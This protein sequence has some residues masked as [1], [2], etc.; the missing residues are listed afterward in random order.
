[1]LRTI[2]RSSAFARASTLSL[3]LQLLVPCQAAWAQAPDQVGAWGPVLDWGVQ[4]K[5][6]V[7]LPTSKVLVW[8]T[9]ENARVWN[10]AT[11][12]FVPVPATFGDLHCAAQA[13]LADGRAIVIGGVLVDPHIGTKVTAIFDPFS[14]TWTDGRPMNYARWYGTATTLPDGRLLATSGDDEHGNR[15]T[16]PEIYDPIADTWTVLTGANRNQN[17]Y[18]FMYVL[19]NG[20]IYEAGTR[21]DT[22][23]L[24]VA[25]TGSWT[26][27]PDNSFGS[28]GYAECDA[29]YAPGKVV[30]AGGGDP[31][32]ADAAVIDMTAGSPQWRKIASM[33]FPRRRH[34]MVI[35]LDGSV[36]AVGGT[37]TADKESDAVLQGEIWNP[38]SELWTTVAAMSE[39]RMYH[40]AALLLPDGRVV[41]AGGEASG[42]MHAQIYSPPYLFKG[43]RPTIGSAP[44]SVSYG[45]TFTLSTPDAGSIDRVAILR[46]CAATHAID[47]NERYV[48]LT[49][50]PGSVAGTLSVDAPANSN[51]APPGYYMLVI[52]N[53]S[54]VPSVA[55]WIRIDSSG[56][57]APGTISGRV[58][59]TGSGNGIAGASV[60]YNGGATTSDAAGNYL[61]GNVPPGEHIVTAS[62]SGYASISKSETV[63]PGSTSMLDFELA[64]PGRIVGR[65]TSRATGDPI[66]GASVS[67]ESGNVTTNAAGQY[68]IEGLPPG[69]Q[70]V[71]VSA[72]GYVTSD[73]TIA[74]ASGG[75]T[76]LDFALERARPY[77]EG[78]VLDSG[79]SQPIVGATVSY[80]MDSTTTDRLG[81][82]RFPDVAPGTYDV[83]AAAA[84]YASKTQQAV[85]GEVGYTA[86]DFALERT[87]PRPSSTLTFAPLADAQIQMSTGSNSG[88]ATTMRVRAGDPEYRIYIKFHAAGFTGAVQRAHLR[89]YCVDPSEDAGSVYR[90]PNGWTESTVT[91]LNAPPISGDSLAAGGQAFA[92][93][94]LEWD[95]TPEVQAGDTVSFALRSR[96]TNSCIFSTREGSQPPQLVVQFEA[97]ATSPP[98]ITF[99]SPASGR[100]GT[101]VVLM[102]SDFIGVT[103]VAFSG[104]PA[105]YVVDSPTRLHATVPA[106]ATTGRISVRNPAGT[107]SSTQDFVVL[108]PSAGSTLTFFPVADAHVYS[109]NPTSNYGSLGTLRARRDSTDY[110]FYLQFD[111]QGITGLVKSAKL[112]LYVTDPSPVGGSMFATSNHYADHSGPWTESGINWNNAPPLSGSAFG[113]LGTVSTDTWVEFDVT[114]AITA[115]GALSFG[116][117]STNTNSVYYSSREGAH[118]PM[119]EVQMV[120]SPSTGSGPGPSLGIGLLPARPNPFS[121]S[122]VIGFALPHAGHVRLTI[123][124]VAGRAVRTLLDQQAPAG[125]RQQEWDGIEGSG[126]LAPAGFY[127]YRLEFDGQSRAGKLLLRR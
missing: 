40:S 51:L 32:F 95:V 7:L 86:L 74:V 111:V 80:G 12:A 113:T 19:P 39:A 15:V 97:T 41:S 104:T 11:G 120:D 88:N 45:S 64:P 16:L 42:R 27:G 61:L 63:T 110:Q 102:G 100:I 9:G 94:W 108:P 53:A 47:M 2:V 92:N 58:T 31:A 90:V 54:G 35:L 70:S 22:W 50:R 101:E 48:P 72:Y 8:P 81:H 14:N 93:T 25:G 34:N 73:S 118:P 30:R 52:R 127:L 20:R 112:H 76:T 36:M 117:S 75:E 6:M 28:N 60:S 4:G 23:S 119:L 106:G 78:E 84:D 103:E 57:L 21:T 65:V 91:S 96:S 123:Y 107:G 115:N 10:P 114:S 71:V 116:V 105:S 56:N 124:N 24:D 83:T 98:T 79:T 46:P 77:I 3:L 1:M 89:L 99:V 55:S 13:T 38:N 85:V 62:A 44:G 33:S 5:H 122:T 26:R 68:R 59:A 43:A 82:Y 67:H 49:H 125:S 121:A 109:G 18:P 87:A 69:E 37:R 66:S 17:L 29:M 126:H